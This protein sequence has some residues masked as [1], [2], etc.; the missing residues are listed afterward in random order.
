MKPVLTFTLLSLPFM[1]L[2]AQEAAPTVARE[3]VYLGMVADEH[4]AAGL[5]VRAV[6]PAS[7]AHKADVR[8]GDVVLRVEQQA[9][10]T[11]SELRRVVAN[12]VRGQQLTVELLREGKPLQ[13]PVVLEARP[14]SLSRASQAEPVLG[15]DKHI[16][17]IALSDSIRQEIRRHR[18]VLREQLASL[19]DA[20]EPRTVTLELQAIR[21]LARD[22]HAGR[23]GWMSGRA[24][25]ISVRFR[26]E[27]GSVILYGANNLV[28]LE[29]YGLHG[30]MTARYELNTEV[31]RRS[32]PEPVLQRLHRLR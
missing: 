15:A 7:P 12:G 17:P 4:G 13:V 6:A 5:L 24:G 19:P 9:I 2:A 20:F 18:R 32:L 22:A 14:D 25:E 3:R 31:A 10:S 11:R 29:L 8:V 27:E 23:P 16:Q 30:Q 26:D 1:P 21:D 28:T